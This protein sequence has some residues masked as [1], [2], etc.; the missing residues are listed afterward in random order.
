MILFQK[1][2]DLCRSKLKCFLLNGYFYAI[3][4]F[5]HGA[6][7]VEPQTSLPRPVF[8]G[9]GYK[10]GQTSNDTEVITGAARRI[11]HTEI[12]LKLWRDGFS[13]NDGEMRAYSDPINKEF[14][15]SIKKG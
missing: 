13:V 4:D 8:Q 9:T 2:L 15:E 12:T 6:E 1:C 7:V 3:S 5:R 10:L 11:S 14:L